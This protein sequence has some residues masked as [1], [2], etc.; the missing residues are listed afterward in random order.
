[1]DLI[2]GTAA[3]WVEALTDDRVWDQQLDG[4]RFRKAFVKLSQTRRQ[5]PAPAD[6]LEAMPPREQLALTKQP[7]PADPD[8]PEMKKCFEELSKVLGMPS[9]KKADNRH[10]HV[11]PRADGI[12]ARC[13]GPGMCDECNRELALAGAKAVRS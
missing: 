8:S 4:P 12:K 13:G 1:M 10:G 3:M 9:R 7:I 11:T 6:F 5:W 2:E